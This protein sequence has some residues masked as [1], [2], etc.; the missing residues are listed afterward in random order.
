MRAIPRISITGLVVA[1]ELVKTFMYLRVDPDAQHSGFVYAQAIAVSNGLHPNKNFLSPYGITGPTIN[2]IWLSLTEDSLLSLVLFYG[3]ITVA[4]GYLI[5]RI[6]SRYVGRTIAILLNLIWVMTLAT[7]NPWP[8]VL[9]TFLCLLSFSILIENKSKF[10]SSVSSSAHFLLPIVIALQLSIFTRIQL[11]LVPGVIS[12]YFILN[13]KHL[14]RKLIRYWFITNFLLGITIL[15]TMYWLEILHPYLSQAI[16]WP[17]TDFSHP[18]FNLSWWFS[19]VWFPLS[20]I[21]ISCLILIGV[22]IYQKRKMGYKTVFIVAVTTIFFTLYSISINDFTG[23]NTGTLKTFPGLI[24]NISVNFQFVFWYSAGML[25]IV[26]CLA[27]VVK[28][29]KRE[30]I[31]T[32]SSADVEYFFILLMGVTGISQLYPLRDNVHLWF[33]APLLIVPSAYFLGFNGFIKTPTRF[34]VIV[35]LSSFMF[36]Q[37]VALYNF[38]S[39]DRAPLKSYEL[40]GMLANS[41]NHLGVDSSIQLLSSHIYGRVLRNNCVDSL[42]SVSKGRYSSI[43]GNFSANSFGNFT[44]NVPTVDPS[45]VPAR[46]IFECG[47]SKDQIMESLQQGLIIVF[48]RPVNTDEKLFDVLFSTSENEN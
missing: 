42:F 36:I 10:Q 23:S 30:F 35:I 31:G 15:A 41:E 33:I 43:D 13:R 27:S 40:R 38:L 44:E 1:L 32:Q 21:F 11:L 46:F 16:L 22:K 6:S 34:S 7:T 8:S 48:T 18:T 14:N 47:I 19:L 17:L 9:S 28:K 45:Q 25:F 2:G 26:G 39:I 5:Q 4:T 20:F 37:N 29:G 24:K 12:V 3:L